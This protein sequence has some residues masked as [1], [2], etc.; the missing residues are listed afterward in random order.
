MQ[1]HKQLR[2]RQQLTSRQQLG[3]YSKRDGLH[4]RLLPEPKLV[5]TQLGSRLQQ[6][7]SLQLGSRMQLWRT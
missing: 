5:L 1:E 6:G 3:S 4:V 2:S 7:S